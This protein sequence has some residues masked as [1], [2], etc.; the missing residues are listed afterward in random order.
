M[1]TAD[2]IKALALMCDSLGLDIFAVGGTIIIGDDTGNVKIM[3]LS[4]NASDMFPP[5]G[6]S[7]TINTVST[8]EP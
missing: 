7:E 8:D 4:G 2:K 6:W 1:N 3:T 5:A